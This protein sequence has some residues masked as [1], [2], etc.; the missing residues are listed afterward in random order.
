MAQVTSQPLTPEMRNL[1]SALRMRIRLYVWLEGLSLAVIWLGLTFWIGLGLDYGLVR[2]GAG[3]LPLAARVVLLAVIGIVLAAILYKFILR[4][5]FVPLANHS[6]ALLMERKF[7]NFDDSLVTAV[8]LDEHR[9]ADD[10][11]SD[12][13]VAD[14]LNQAQHEL[15]GVRLRK[16]F[17]W[18]RLMRAMLLAAIFIAITLGFFL[19]NET[20]FTLWANRLYGL[21]D[22]TWPRQAQ[23][24]LVDVQVSYGEV[25]DAESSSSNVTFGPDRSLKTAR[26][27]SLMLRV[28]ADADAPVV[29]RTCTIYY[30]NSEGE[31]GRANMRKIGDVRDG[32]QLYSFEDKPFRA[33]IANLRFDVLGYDHRLRDYTIQVVDGPELSNIELDCVFP[34]YLVNER[35][36]L[37]MPRTETYR[38]GIQLPHGTQI[39]L[40]AKANKPIVSAT[41]TNTVTD[42]VEV[43]A[44][45]A[46]ASESFA[47]EIPSLDEDAMFTISLLDI[48]GVSS[49]ESHGIFIASVEDRA[50]EV[51]IRLRGV[52]TAVTP[53]AR[54]PLVGTIE[55]DYATARAWAE[56]FP[57]GGVEEN[58]TIEIGAGGEI[59]AAVDLRAMRSRDNEPL[60]LEPRDKLTLTVKATDNNDLHAEPNI[61]AGDRYQ[62]DIVTPDELLN[63]LETREL[64]L[65]RRY[66]QIIEEITLTRD[67]LVRVQNELTGAVDRGLEPEDIRAAEEPAADESANNSTPDGDE[68]SEDEIIREL[69]LRLLRVERAIQQSQKSTQEVLG[70]AVSFEDIREE[71][72]NNRVDSEERK[73]RLQEQIA[74]PLRSIVDDRFPQFEQRL[75]ALRIDLNDGNDT[76]A[77]TANSA[78]D[79]ANELVAALESV[80]QRMLDLETYNELIDIVRSLLE[81]QEEL[82]DATKKE[83]AEDLLDLLQ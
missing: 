11:Y 73:Q 24:E 21:D 70:V 35:L 43:I 81:D 47:Y 18:G 51:D 75:E 59:D 29:P 65:R 42:E 12:D 25:T 62:I 83:Q 57:S 10:H 40:R 8:E 77:E 6:M 63:M 3:E 28:R 1:L 79:E 44:F 30:T 46:E 71:L 82:I 32:Y 39:T 15:G 20:A 23:I 80:L 19:R 48:D 49:R 67:S 9:H 33:I 37:W 36:S 45:G 72:I 69:R 54:I 16:I 38:N 17:N 53:D 22:S 5:A 7:S 14:I 34:K 74:Q 50:P 60:E 58:Q 31:R 78:V 76:A 26:G 68:P 52:S 27:A 4:R 66:E 2:L 55:D 64:G 61:G 56:V 13:M 41:V